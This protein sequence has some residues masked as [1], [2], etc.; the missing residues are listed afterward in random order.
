MKRRAQK[1]VVSASASVREYL[2]DHPTAG[3]AE[4]VKALGVKGNIVY[5]VRHESNLHH[6]PQ[7]KSKVAKV[8]RPADVSPFGSLTVL[9]DGVEYIVGGISITIK[10]VS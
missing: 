7:V 5:N 4:I 2:K 8:Q 6:K 1:K 3:T 10:R 9:P